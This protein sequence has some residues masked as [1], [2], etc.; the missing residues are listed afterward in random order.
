MRSLREA[1]GKIDA[2]QPVGARAASTA[3]RVSAGSAPERLLAEHRQP[4]SSAAIACRA[5]SALGVAIT[6]PSR[7]SV[8]R[9]SKRAVR[10]R[11][12]REIARA[13]QALRRRVG[14]GGGLRAAVFE[15]R[16]HAVEPIQPRPGKPSRRG[17]ERARARRSQGTT[18]AFMNP[19]GRS[20]VASSARPSRSSGNACVIAPA[21]RAARATA[22]KRRAHAAHVERG[23]RSCALTRRGRAS[24]TSA[25][26]PGAA[27]PGGSPR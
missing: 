19:S 9:S 3:A 16:L 20:R 17:V 5:C 11:R 1:V 2:E 27:R 23:S 15:Q 21:G 26:S 7:S 6:S 8:S 10:A 4:R 12:R 22:S 25:C 14:D 24:S 13:R 18:T